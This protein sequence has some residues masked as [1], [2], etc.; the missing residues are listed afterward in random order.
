MAFDGTDEKSKKNTDL[1]EGNYHS[2]RVGKAGEIL[3]P[4]PGVASTPRLNAPK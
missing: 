1:W 2:G 3:I 4:L